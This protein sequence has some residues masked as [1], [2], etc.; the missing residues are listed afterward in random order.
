MFV[1]RNVGNMVP[2]AKSQNESYSKSA[3]D[4]ALD[5]LNIRHIL[6]CGHSECGAM[7][8]I[9][10]GLNHQKSDG[11]REWLQYGIEGKFSP[12]DYN[13]LS[14]KNVLHQ[15]DHLMTFERVREKVT[16][17]TLQLHA[18]WFDIK[19]ADVFYYSKPSPD[20]QKKW[21]LIDTESAT[22]L[23]KSL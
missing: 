12:Y 6:V 22:S 5:V 9:H 14:H 18:W 3:I 13:E 21:V 17:G 16:A 20:E 1:L 23:L 2:P 7:I 10:Q 15:L 8:A 11:I 4:F 19:N